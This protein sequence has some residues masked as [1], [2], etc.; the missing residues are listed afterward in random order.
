MT[1]LYC[2]IEDL[3]LHGCPRGSLA[4]EARPVASVDL[5]SSC[6]LNDHGLATGS[7]VR[8]LALP[9]G[10]LP[11]ALSESTTYYAIRTSADVF[12]LALTAGGA[13][14]S[15]GTAGTYPWGV[16]H[17]T[18]DVLEAAIEYCSRLVDQALPA[19]SYPADSPIPLLIVG[20]TAKLA[21]QN[22]ARRLGRSNP[23]IDALALGAAE[24]LKILRQG[25]LS[26]RDANAPGRT[27]LA[28]SWGGT[29]RGWGTSSSE[30]GTIP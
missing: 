25:M 20:I 7:T 22:A 21:A 29:E 2:A 4:E 30:G 10:A 15:L 14:I 5:P 1:S 6:A 8:A 13:A 18:D 28:V 23:S 17:P 27:N 24:E 26:V 11:S 12:Q 3:Y 19:H 16:Y 9:G